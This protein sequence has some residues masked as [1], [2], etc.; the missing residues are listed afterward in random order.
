M[1]AKIFPLTAAALSLGFAFA[2]TAQAYEAGDWITR[3]GA[4]YVDPKSDNHDVVGV[5]AAPG[6]TGSIQYFVTPHLAA[7]LLLA[8][9]FR[10][11]I[12]LNG[13]GST[14]ASTRQLPPTLSLV[15]YPGSPKGWHPF[16]GAGI[17]YTLFFDEDTRGALEGTDLKLDDSF[18]LALVAGAAFDLSPRWELMVDVRYIDID[19]DASLDGADLGTVEIDPFAYGF[20]VGYRF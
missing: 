2:P 15:W 16:V 11:D 6:L 17:N 8:V 20:A 19:T 18:G 13:D 5:D 7:D 9:P 4:H 1:T 14:V 10:H 12:T 3:I